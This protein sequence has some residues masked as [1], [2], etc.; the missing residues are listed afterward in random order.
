MGKV[1]KMEIRRLLKDVFFYAYPVIMIILIILCFV[2]ASETKDETAP[3]NMILVVSENIISIAV[4]AAGIVTI[5]HC[6]DE[7]K[8]GYTKNLIGNISG[9]HLLVF[10]KLI[11]GAITMIIYAGFN[12]L[13][14]FVTYAVNAKKIVAYNMTY[15]FPESADLMPEGKEHLWISREEFESELN[16]E[17][18]HEIMHYILMIV[19]GIVTIVFIIMLYEIFKSSTFCYVMTILISVS[20]VE[21]L[22]IQLVAL[23]S[24]KIEIS[25]YL[26]NSQF[27]YFNSALEDGTAVEATSVTNFWIRNLIYLAVFAG[28]A[29]FISKKKDAA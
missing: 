10:S 13:Y 25:R 29:M 8:H 7:D 6:A 3:L 20:I 17:L 14:V 2:S 4:I 28:A 22:I 5:D 18:N 9:R 26:F 1:L 12:F 15:Y 23:I 21:Q 11:I 27:M 19:A 16:E 24:E